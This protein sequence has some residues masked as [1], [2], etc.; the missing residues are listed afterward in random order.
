MGVICI[1]CVKSG[2][3]RLSDSAICLRVRP[4]RCAGKPGIAVA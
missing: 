1:A 4:I 2:T 3:A